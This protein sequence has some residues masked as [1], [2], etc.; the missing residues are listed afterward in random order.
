MPA[1]RFTFFS[2]VF[3]AP[4]APLITH[5]LWGGKRRNQNEGTWLYLL[6][7]S[8]RFHLKRK[9]TGFRSLLGIPFVFFRIRLLIKIVV[10]LIWALLL[11]RRHFFPYNVS[12][13]CCLCRFHPSFRVTLFSVRFVGFV[14]PSKAFSLKGFTWFHI[15]AIEFC[16]T[17]CTVP[18]QRMCAS[19]YGFDSVYKY[20]MAEIMLVFPTCIPVDCQ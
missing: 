19:K 10:C 4:I 18:R 17:L 15:K 1:A 7:A 3:L 11:P 16:L 6:R 13:F 12:T 9:Q 2:S 8:I 20:A 14:K 5:D